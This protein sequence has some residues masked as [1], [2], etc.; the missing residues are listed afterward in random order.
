MVA[1]S[2][3]WLMAALVL[4]AV[5]SDVR[6]YTI[7][8]WISAAIIGLALVQMA[9][10]GLGWAAW[11]YLV[12]AAAVLVVGFG[13]FV[14]NC[15]GAGDVKLLTALALWAG[16]AGLSGLIVWTA[17]GGGGLALV[18]LVADWLRRRAGLGADPVNAGAAGGA[19][20][21]AACVSPTDPETAESGP[22]RGRRPLPYAVAIACGALYV[23]VHGQGLVLSGV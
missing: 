12:C 19:D 18:V 3:P 11:P 8:N 15:L 21:T 14:C 6:T 9:L 22:S 1:L 20:P 2:L 7:P 16:P 10:L 17:I 4:W 5:V 23:F 13:L